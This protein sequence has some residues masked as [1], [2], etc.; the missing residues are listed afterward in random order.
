MANPLP[1]ISIQ[2]L[3]GSLLTPSLENATVGDAMHAGIVACGIDATAAEVGRIMVAHHVHC[4]V[5]MHEAQTDSDAPYVW[6]IVSDLDLMR[7]CLGA[8]AESTAGAL[9]G[10]PTISVKTTAPLRDAADLLVRHGVGHVVVMQPETL[11]PVGV[12]STLDV[13]RILVWGEA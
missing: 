2:P 5:V 8:G 7:A 11:R 1:K 12:L 4:V 3:H 10:R 13:A 9:A 6:G